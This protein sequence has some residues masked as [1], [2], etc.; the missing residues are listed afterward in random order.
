MIASA[1]GK[2]VSAMQRRKARGFTLTEAIMVIVITGILAGMVAVFIRKPVQGFFDTARRAALVDA[3]DTVSRR[4]SRDLHEALP[5]S[6]RSS[7]PAAL[8][9]LHVRSA[10]RYREQIAP[11][12]SA[13][14]DPL[15][16]T[17]ADTS[18]DVLGPPISVQA[19]DSVVV[20]NLGAGV[21]GSDAYVGTGTNRRLAA[22]PFGASLSNVAITSAAAFTAA[23]PAKRFQ[24]VDTP[25]SYVCSGTQMRRYSGYAI[26]PGQPVPPA[27]AGALIAD[28]LTA[29]SFAYQTGPSER[30]ALVTLRLDLTDTGE[31][32][33]LIYQI[34]VNNAP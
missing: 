8:E 6:V 30:E 33:S 15:D 7:T 19:G 23:S 12:P 18:F 2:V 26:L 4:I 13:S 22:A 1:K 11:P 24:V 32:V 5:N 31:T 25:V 21:T 29:C 3:A 16:F 10:G 28:K 9:F 17:T 34:H 20:Y 14:G 27:V